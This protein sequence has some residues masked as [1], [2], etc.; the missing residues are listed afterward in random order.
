MTNANEY[1]DLISQT[2]IMALHSSTS[3]SWFGRNTLKHFQAENIHYPNNNT[4]K[5]GK[6]P[7]FSVHSYTIMV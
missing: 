1:T 4:N 7:H 2:K 5:W 6:C 3:F